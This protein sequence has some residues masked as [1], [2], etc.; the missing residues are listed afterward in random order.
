MSA[1]NIVAVAFFVIVAVF[2]FF[3]A[4]LI[5]PF[6]EFDEDINPEMKIFD[7][8]AIPVLYHEKKGEILK[9]LI[10]KEMN[11]SK[12][13]KK[14]E[15]NPG[16]IKRHLGDLL[17]YDLIRSIRKKTNDFNLTETYYRATAKKYTFT[18]KW[19]HLYGWIE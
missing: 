6:G 5:H 11:I 18:R 2:L 19:D 3:S 15:I 16:T 8:K 10:K 9:L 14:L 7:P 17:K 12:L 4:L 13:S 1:R